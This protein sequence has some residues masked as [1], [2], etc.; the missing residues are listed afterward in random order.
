MTKLPIS[1]F[2]PALLAATLGGATEARAQVETLPEALALAYQGNPTLTG[3]R[4]DL[5]ALDEEVPINRAEGLPTLNVDATYVEFVSQSSNQFTAPDRN[6]GVN[7]QLLVPVY[8]GGAVRNAVRG[9]EMRVEAGRAELRATESA[10]FSRTVAAY[11]DVLRTEALAALAQNQVDVLGADLASTRGRFELGDVT[12]TD[13]GQSQS[14]VALAQSE[15]RIALAGLIT[16]RE[17][18]LQLVGDVP[19]DLAPP[20]PLPDI[21][22]TIESAVATALDNNPDLAAAQRSVDAARFDNEAAGAERSPRVS[23]FSN[24]E[25]SDFFGTLGGPVAA[26]FA[27]SEVTGNVGVRLTFPL[28]RGGAP[29]ARHRRA[30]AREAS[31][32]ERAVLIEREIVQQTRAA[33]ANWQASLAVIE[34]ARV[35]IEGAEI[36]LEGVRAEST[37]GNR[38]VLDVLNAQ[39]ELL[40][41]RV[42]LITARRNAYVAGFTLLAAMGLAEARSL[43]LETGAALYDP[44]VNSTRVRNILWDW[45]RDADPVVQAT[46][47]SGW[48]ATT[49]E[50]APLST[51]H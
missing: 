7:A 16:A 41:A 6:L 43:N 18:F 29:A 4:A 11:M 42:Q 32:L 46:G 34:N 47:T 14:R 10:I 39:Q 45:S 25:Y 48:P 22:D 40:S 24:A 28:F 30:Q 20:P 1:A 3:A 44:T 37:V 13:F 26:G 9:A 33:F 51:S 50:F 31:A 36:G 8:S 2:L 19:G 15:L 12:R 27:Q 38:T 5:R 17:T 35:A 49:D 21:P 23:L